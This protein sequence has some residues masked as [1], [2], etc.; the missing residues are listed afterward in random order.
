MET[1]SSCRLL[2]PEI[3][4]SLTTIESRGG[5]P[6][7]SVLYDGSALSIPANVRFKAGCME[8]ASRKLP[9]LC[10]SECR[11]VASSRSAEYG[12][13]SFQ[14]RIPAIAKRRVRHGESPAY[15][16]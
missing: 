3:E 10:A 7:L 16:R 4:H 5:T 9:F 8:L 1:E 11:R 14:N 12:K 2:R 6:S 15:L 13:H